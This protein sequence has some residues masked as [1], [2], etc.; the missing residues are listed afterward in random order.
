MS[1]DTKPERD[2]SLFGDDHIATYRA[3]DGE[4]GHIW[5]GAPCLILTSRRKN[6]EIREVPLIYGMD[7]GNPVIVASK[8]GAPEDPFW[9]MDLVRT[10][11]AKVQILGEVFDVT[12]HTATADE[13]P[14]LWATMTEIWP[15]Y[16]T[17]Q[18]NTD[19]DIP[20]VVLQR[21]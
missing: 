2:Y 12:A 17:Y 3:T 20:V 9:Y 1:D 7:D 18:S 19:R 5:N 15:D 16:D 10:P 6:G 4:T 14:A 11:Q 21:S 8:G 13:K